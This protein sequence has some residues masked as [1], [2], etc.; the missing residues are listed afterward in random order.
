M[1]P[2]TDAEGAYVVAEKVREAVASTCS[3][4]R[5]ASGADADGEHR[6][7]DLPHARGRR[8]NCCAKRTMRCTGPSTAARPRPRA[9]RSVAAGRRGRLR[10]LRSDARWAFLGPAGTFSEEALLSLGIDDVEPVPCSTSPRCS[11]PWSAVRPTAGSCRSRT[12]RGSVPATLDALA[13]ETSSRSRASSSST[14]TTRS[15]PRRARSSP[16]S[17]SVVGHPQATG[18]CRRWLSRNLPGPCVV[19]ANS[20]AEAVQRAVGK[21]GVAALG[22]VMAAE[23]YGGEIVEPPSRTTRETRRASS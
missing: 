17:P 5:A 6:P 19:A 8:K 11:R 2:E 18:Q 22:T 10:R 12:R 1:L 14:S 4:T 23:L 13:F 15:S 3:S 9:A 16:R 20:T 21:P 7:R